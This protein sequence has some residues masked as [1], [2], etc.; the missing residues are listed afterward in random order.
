[1]DLYIHSF[2]HLNGVVFK[3]LSAGTSLSFYLYLEPV[4]RAQ[5]GPYH[6]ISQILTHHFHDNQSDNWSELEESL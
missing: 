3:Y 4:Q 5:Q 1:M 6:T 2:I